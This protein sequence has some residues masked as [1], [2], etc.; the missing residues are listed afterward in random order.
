MPR[1]IIGGHSAG[2]LKS[3]AITCRSVMRL[4]S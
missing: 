1:C 4:P 2:C 3:F